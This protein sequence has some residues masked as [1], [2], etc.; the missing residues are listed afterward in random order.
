MTTPFPTNPDIIASP[1]T[2]LDNGYP[3]DA[4]LGHDSTDV[5]DANKNGKSPFRGGTDED[6]EEDSDERKQQG[7]KS[8]RSRAG[9]ISFVT[10]NSV[11]DNENGNGGGGGGGGGGSRGDTAPTSAA[12][13]TTLP[14]E[15]NETRQQPK[16][17][18]LVTRALKWSPV[19]VLEN[20]GS[21]ARDHLASERTWLAYIRTSLA[22]SSAGVALVQLFT[23]AANRSAAGGGAD[24]FSSHIQRFA[25]P[26]GATT[27]L[28]GLG[29]CLLGLYRYFLIQSSLT[30]GKFP[31]AR[32]EV[33]AVSLLL[34]ALTGVVFGVLV[35]YPR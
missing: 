16:K 25:R 7:S 2:T 20:S 29:V 19:L 33:H 10:T 24:P 34:G 6:D 18:G 32:L 15:S 30:T 22:I 17:D 27:V 5:T 12:A 13:S 1:S 14:P 11:G 21:V 31:T 9:N 3:R 35:A 4:R 28:I 23:I 8:R 26:L